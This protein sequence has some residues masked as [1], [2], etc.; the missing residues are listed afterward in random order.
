MNQDS[1]HSKRE[2]A[3]YLGSEHECSYLPGREAR[4]LFFDP[5]VRVDRRLAQWL[6]DQGFRR[7]GGYMYRPHCRDCR[8]CIPVRIP[9]ERFSRNRSQRRCWRRNQDLRV[10]SRPPRFRQEQFDL[11]S[12]YAASR[13]SN[14]PMD[15]LSPENYLEFLTSSWADTRFFEFRLGDRLAAVAVTDI[16]AG[17]LSALYTFFEPEWESR[18]L[19]VFAVLWQLERARLLGLSYLYLGYWIRDCRKMSYKDRYR[20]LEAWDGKQWQGFE[21]NLEVFPE[22]G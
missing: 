19:G 5:R 21:A 6:A 16:L 11:Y 15:N 17:G 14:G 10:I 4:S 18:S 1:P 22:R 8:A 20:P 7:S 13:H 3:L 12:R 2:F 9:V